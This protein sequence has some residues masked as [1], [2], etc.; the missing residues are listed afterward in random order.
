MRS[1]KRALYFTTEE[2]RELGFACDSYLDVLEQCDSDLDRTKCEVAHNKIFIE[3][4]RREKLD[5]ERTERETS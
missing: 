3:L 2:L 4:E 1:Q 5:A